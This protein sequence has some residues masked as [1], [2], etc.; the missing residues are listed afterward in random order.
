MSSTIQHEPLRVLVVD[1]NRDAADT[2]CLL[3][4]LWGHDARPAYD[5]ASAL[6]VAAEHPPDIVLCDLGL[7][8]M[9]ATALAAQFGRGPALVALTGYTDDAHRRAAAAA[10]FDPYLVKP[11]D[12]EALRELLNALGRD[13]LL[14]R[15]V[16]DQARWTEELIQRARSLRAQLQA[17][18]EDTGNLLGPPRSS[19]T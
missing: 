2:L 18:V 11:C 17:A 13:L 9:D 8:D 14:A 7:P 19:A 4:S 3:A 15:T 1:D 5:G 6:R 10:G 12:P 16:A